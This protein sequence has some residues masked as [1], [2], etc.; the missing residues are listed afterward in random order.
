MTGLVK[1]VLRRCQVDL[2]KD[3]DY[4]RFWHLELVYDVKRAIELSRN[5]IDGIA[6]V[7]HKE[8]EARVCEFVK[9]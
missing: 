7:K 5:L 9:C 1:R 3:I 2:V 4:F 8:H 6:D